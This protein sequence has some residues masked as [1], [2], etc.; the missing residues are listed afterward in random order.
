MRL[1]MENSS[2]VR[3]FS[4]VARLSS[5]VRDKDCLTL[6][7]ALN[8]IFH[9]NKPVLWP[10]WQ[11]TSTLAKQKIKANNIQPDSPYHLCMW[12]FSND[13]KIWEVYLSPLNLNLQPNPSS[14]LFIHTCCQIQYR[15]AFIKSPYVVSPAE[16]WVCC[17][18]RQC[19]ELSWAAQPKGE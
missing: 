6:V 19:L 9:Q 12:T 8:K 3:Y 18:T 1:K 13:R 7:L 5:D 4:P 16:P 17:D 11:P 15:Q 10:H 2:S 14:P